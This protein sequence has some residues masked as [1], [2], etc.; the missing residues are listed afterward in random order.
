MPQRRPWTESRLGILVVGAKEGLAGPGFGPESRGSNA[1]GRLPHL[2]RLRKCLVHGRD[3]RWCRLYRPT[4]YPIPSTGRT[5]GYPSRKPHSQNTA[6]G[7]EHVCQALLPAARP[8]EC[9]RLDADD[10]NEVGERDVH[11]GQVQA[12]AGAEHRVDDG[13]VVTRDVRLGDLEPTRGSRPFAACR[14]LTGERDPRRLRAHV[15]RGAD[16]PSSEQSDTGA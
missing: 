1:V 10:A 4:L 13:A 7:G 9:A 6:S 12:P 5:R 15:A 3:T 8:C 2:R 11:V 14:V 16:E